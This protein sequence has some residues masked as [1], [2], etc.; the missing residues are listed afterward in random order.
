MVAR[1]RLRTI[2]LL[3]AVAAC[4]TAPGANDSAE[5]SAG[6]SASVLGLPPVVQLRLD[7]VDVPGPTKQDLDVPRR[8]VDLLPPSARDPRAWRSVEAIATQGRLMTLRE[9]TRT[10][11]GQDLTVMIDARGRVTLAVSRSDDPSLPESVRALARRPSVTLSD[12][13]EIR[14]STRVAPRA[15]VPPAKPVVLR[16][17]GG[18]ARTLGEADLAKLPEAMPPQS[19]SKT[20]EHQLADVVALAAPLDRVSSVTLSFEAAEPVTFGHAA[21]IAKT[22]QLLVKWNRRG[23]LR[24]NEW[25]GDRRVRKLEGITGIDVDVRP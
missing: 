19:D 18:G 9:P 21:L 25:E 17:P 20:P 10:Y 12:I 13:L 2:P 11:P 8:L 24:V 5:A 16:A 6:P 3:L 1:A 22:G 4:T 14:V 15:E 7:D 23:E